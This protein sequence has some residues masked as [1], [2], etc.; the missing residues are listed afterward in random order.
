M[1]KLHN[2]V[3][4]Y[5]FCLMKFLFIGDYSNFHVSIADELRRRGHETTIL[6]SGSRCMDTRR[7]INLQRKSG[8]MGGFR[9]LY[10]LFSILPRLSGYDVVQLINPN[11]LELR[12]AKIRYIYD[13]LRRA[14]GKMVLSLAG[15]DPYYVRACCKGEKFRY[16]EYRIGRELSPFAKSKPYEEMEWQ[17]VEMLDHC[18]YIYD[19]VDV[20][21]SCLYEY[22][23]VG[24]DYLGDKLTYIGIP[25]D[26]D[27]IDYTPLQADDVVQLFVGVKSEYREYKGADRLLAVA[28]AL[29][30]DCPNRCR[31][32]VVEN[33]PYVEYMN[34]MRQSDIVLDQL[35]SYTP[36]TNALGAMAMGKV[37]VSGAEPEYY[38]FIGEKELRPI[39]NAVPDDEA[40]YA[41]LYSLL[42]DPE[43]LRE[44]SEQ[45]RKLVEKHNSSSVV[46]DRYLNHINHL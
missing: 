28:Q 10:D 42:K 20:A 18:K 15:S 19:S 38:D 21:V 32:R 12:P 8:L 16:S 1:V 7:D 36:A 5:Y 31:V 6:S 2:F 46:V 26:V 4:F 22:D 29:E 23:I 27:N 3:D 11:F 14:N 30:R 35:Y 37:V 13:V 44:M 25:I 43:R 17:R 24:R 34:M 40:L 45:G 9:Y 33:L 39:V 41:S